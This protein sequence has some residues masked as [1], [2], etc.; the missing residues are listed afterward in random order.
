[1]LHLTALTTAVFA[2]KPTLNVSV[3]QCHQS[4]ENDMLR[5]VVRCK[6]A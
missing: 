1:M 5:F 3:R 2:P 6:I 4:D